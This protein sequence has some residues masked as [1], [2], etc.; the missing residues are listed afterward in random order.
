M[1]QLRQ[2]LARQI[3]ALFIVA[4][5]IIRVQILKA[6]AQQH[7]R[8]SVFLQQLNALLR[9]L[10]G[11]DQYAVHVFA[12]RGNDRLLLAVGS[13]LR[14]HHDRAVAVGLQ[15]LHALLDFDGEQG[16]GDI[17]YDDRNRLAGAGAQPARL[18]V[19]DIAHLACGADDVLP[20][21]WGNALAVLQ[22]LGYRAHGVAG[23]G[24]DV[25]KFRPAFFISRHVNNSRMISWIRSL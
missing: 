21:L 2:M 17:A 5:D 12:Q 24:G 20:R 22:R 19:G 15:R 4:H 10:R 16:I 13:L 9:F 14:I 8:H 18:R 1:S 11:A 7:E 25:R 6:P 3:A 23:L